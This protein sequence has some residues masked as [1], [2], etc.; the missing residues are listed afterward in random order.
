MKD[1]ILSINI[2]TLGLSNEFLTVFSRISFSLGWKLSTA[3]IYDAEKQKNFQIVLIAASFSDYA[4]IEFQIKLDFP[5]M[6][7]II[8]F[9]Y[10]EIAMVS[11]NSNLLY[12]I[13]WDL[14]VL[15]IS[16]LCVWINAV[17][18]EKMKLFANKVQIGDGF[19]SLIDGVYNKNG[20]DMKLTEK[21]VLLL[22]MLLK[23]RGKTVSRS[24]IWESIWGKSKKVVTDRVIDTNIVALR[25]IFGDADRQF[26]CLE[27]VFGQG[28]RLTFQ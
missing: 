4:Q 14:S 13:L 27:T 28:Y 16:Q 26:K 7:V 9:D 22:K 20:Y 17:F 10:K 6:I 15:V 2:L 19:F 3:S 5:N 21:Q 12:Y 11:S 23:H 8:L 25:K 1:K 24:L 18:A